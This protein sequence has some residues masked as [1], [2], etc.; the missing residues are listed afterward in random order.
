[1]KFTLESGAG[2]NLI[3]SYS[4]DEIRV[5]AQTVR[6]SCIVTAESVLTSWGPETLEELDTG[7]LETLYALQP[8]LVLFGTGSRQRF[9]PAQVRTALAERGI[10]VESMA[11][12]AACRTY[13]V[14]VQ[15]D[16]RVAAVL[17]L[18]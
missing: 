5:G 10:G 6:S 3:R 11:L 16:R 14:L 7:H 2:Q 9:P 17:F 18:R 4:A 8:E 1:M 15:E 12:G 13:N